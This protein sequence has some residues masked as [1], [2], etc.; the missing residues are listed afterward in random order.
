[1]KADEPIARPPRSE[2]KDVLGARLGATLVESI[3]PLWPDDPQH[4][5][6]DD[7]LHARAGGAGARLLSQPLFRVN[8]PGPP[9]FPEVAAMIKPTEFAGGKTFGSGMHGRRST[10]WCRSPTARFRRRRR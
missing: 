2:I 5:K 7:E 3:D 6:H 9:L 1:M 4:R 10:T 8:N